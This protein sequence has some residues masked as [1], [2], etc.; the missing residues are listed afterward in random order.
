MSTVIKSSI[1]LKSLGNG[2][3]A[4]LLSAVGDKLFL[5]TIAGIA[6]GVKRG[7]MPDKVTPSIG[8]T[9]DFEATPTDT[10]AD[11]VRSGVCFLSQSLMTPIIDALS[12]EVN[13]DGKVVKEGAN[14]VAFAYEV[15][16]VKDGNAAG[17]T[18]VFE[19][20]VQP[21]END[22]LAE[23]RKALADKTAAKQ[24]QLAAPKAAK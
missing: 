1:T 11:V 2:K 10:K 3:A 16:A 23:M 17:F 14:S 15:Y 19:S 6:S 4:A 21:T 18:W 24:A 5:G 13:A 20:A 8:L 9:G 22:P 12:D 7:V